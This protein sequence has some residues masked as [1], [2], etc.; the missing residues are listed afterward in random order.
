MAELAGA[1]RERSLRLHIEDKHDVGAFAGRQNDSLV[2][3]LG[4]SEQR[5]LRDLELIGKLVE[6]TDRLAVFGH[7]EMGLG[8]HRG[9]L[10]GHG[11]C[12]FVIGRNDRGK[13][14]GCVQSGGDR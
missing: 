5:P 10:S 6:C 3:V 12:G 2:V 7:C 9:V 13:A 11:Q 8:G 14:G 4:A 1:A